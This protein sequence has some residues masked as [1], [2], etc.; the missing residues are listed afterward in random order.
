MTKLQDIKFIL[1]DLEGTTTSI[2]FVKD[3]LFPYS[4]KHLVDF[5]SKF[6]SDER[7]QKILT[8]VEQL[9]DADKTCVQQLLAWIEADQKIPPL[10]ELQAMIWEH[11][12]RSGDFTGHVYSDAHEALVKWHQSGIKLGIYSSGSVHAQKLLWG[13]S[14]HGDLNYLFSENFD[15]RIGT[16]QDPESYQHISQILTS[17]YELQAEEILFL[18]DVPAELAAA[19]ESGMQVLQLVRASDGTQASEF[20]SV[21]SFDKLNI[22]Q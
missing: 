18:S 3:T 20:A 17:K 13:Y 7:V 16:K 15:T 5:V 10:K 6:E 21:P 11:G 19:Q 14:D 1:T 4:Q 22:S 8:E 9:K 12:Y 2:T